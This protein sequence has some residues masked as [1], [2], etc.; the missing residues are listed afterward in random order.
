MAL[1]GRRF[2]SSQVA[3]SP[4]PERGIFTA[5]R[6][7]DSERPFLKTICTPP[8]SWKTNVGPQSA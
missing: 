3:F 6:P 2:L 4:E 8:K 1:R 5:V 7:A